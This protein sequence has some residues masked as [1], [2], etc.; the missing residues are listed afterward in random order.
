MMTTPALLV[1]LE[2]IIIIVATIGSALC[3]DTKRGVGILPI[4]AFWRLI[5]G[6][7]IGEDAYVTVDYQLTCLP[8][9]SRGRLSAL[10]RHHV[11]SNESDFH[12]SLYSLL[13][14]SY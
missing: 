5:L 14:L 6:F 11:R 10:C 1:G 13:S 3:G 7:G 8:L 9:F 2:L 12:A 4:L